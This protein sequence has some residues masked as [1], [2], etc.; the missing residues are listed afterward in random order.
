MRPSTRSPLSPSVV[1]YGQ[2][3]FLPTMVR[4][5]T[6]LVLPIGEA[7]PN[8]SVQGGQARSSPMAGLSYSVPSISRGQIDIVDISSPCHID[9]I[10]YLVGPK[11][12]RNTETPRRQE[13]PSQGLSK[14]KLSL[15][16][17]NGG[18]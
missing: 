15:V 13:A 16:H 9:S 2:H 4:E 8:P 6:H 7:H 1:S 17:D 5:D 11:D 14:V 18:T 12:S 10:S 3:L